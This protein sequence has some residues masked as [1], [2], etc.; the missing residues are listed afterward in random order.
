MRVRV[1]LGLWFA[2]LVGAGQAQSQEV[3]R[4]P[5]PGHVSSVAVQRFW[6]ASDGP[7]GP[8]W[9]RPDEIARTY[10]H[11]TLPA[12]FRRTIVLDGDVPA[13]GKLA[14]IFTGPHAGFT[15][16][17]TPSKVR[18]VQRFYD[19]SALWSGQG[20]YPEKTVRDDERQYIGD[21]REVTV[22]LDS[23]LSV[24]VL[25]NGVRALE[26][27]CVFDVMRHQL[28]FSA[29]RNQHLTVAG[30]LAV[31]PASEASVVVRPEER[32]QT[33]LGFGGSPSIPTYVELSDEG[34]KQYW[35]ILRRYN[36]LLDRE[37]PMGS[38]L[39]RD[40][41]NVDDLGDASPHYY[42]DNFPNGEVSSFEYSR[43]VLA[44]GGD[45]IYEMW[46]L[47]PWAQEAYTAE[48]KPVIDAWGKAV[49]RV[50]KP[51]E[52]ARIV[53]G[54]CRIMKE[55]TGSAPL[56]VGIQNEVE[57]PT[58]VFTAMA[59]TLRK[60]LDKAGFQSVKI[61]MADASFLYMGVDR[62]KALSRDAAGWK[63]LDYT[64]AHEYDYQEFFANPDMYDERMIAMHD[65]GSGKEFLATE[66]CL[67]DPHY[68]EPSYRI[69]LN[70]G[71]LYQKNLTKLDAEALMYCWL[72]LDTEQPNFGGSRSL[73]VPDKTRGNVPVASSFQ[74]R[75]L[76]AFSRHVLKGMVRV[77]ATSSDKDL[78]TAAFE[79]TNHATLIVLNR[80][81]TAER[82]KVDWASKRWMQIERTSQT[83]ENAASSSVPAEVVVQPGEIVTLSNFAVN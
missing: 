2:V 25:V 60:E 70:V 52:Y 61:H 33:M 55:R 62:A 79:D 46:A 12:L 66:I 26:Q 73:L 3:L 77:T 51:E 82:L 5:V 28:M 7:I 34:K 54:F 35:E 10:F 65:A 11:E 32:H 21:A 48:G 59:T 8:G 9:T 64:A 50:A 14:W 22:V 27:P 75:V 72:L 16:E 29:P 63:A 37:Y 45:V 83:E 4:L 43:H 80:S 31:A 71:Q 18:L 67:N 41:S 58:A 76:G 74:L 78:L 30:A 69:A 40:L 57:Q 24:T 19:S 56:I 17:L 38:E 6:F 47:P 1:V 23:H 20:S 81:T 15:V 44:M 36:L 49:K 42:G 13:K 68:Q 53:V 39:K